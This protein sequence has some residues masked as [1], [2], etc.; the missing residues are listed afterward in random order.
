MSRYTSEQTVYN[1]L[2]KKTVPL[3]RLDT[4]TMTVT[5]FN[6]DTQTDE[7]KTYHTDF[8]RYHLHFSDSHC[9]DRLRR[10]V[11]EGRIVEYLDDMERKVN[12]AIS[13]S[14]IHI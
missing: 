14:L 10:L 11:N 12:E 13:L 9:P 1:P 7:S 6:A 5:H 3:L 8:I 2:K 4:N